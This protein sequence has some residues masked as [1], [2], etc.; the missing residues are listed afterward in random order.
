MIYCHRCRHF[1][2]GSLPAWEGEGTR[3]G[4]WKKATEKLKEHASHAS[5]KLAE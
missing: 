5:H 1:G 3:A 4:G 2:N